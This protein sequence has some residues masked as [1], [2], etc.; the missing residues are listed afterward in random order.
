MIIDHLGEIAPGFFLLGHAAAPVHLYLA[1]RPVLFD[2][3]FSCLDFL[4]A[5]GIEQTLAGRRPE[6]LCL[7]HSH[8]DHVGAAGML[9]RRFPGLTA[10]AS[11]KAAEVLAKPGAR[12]VIA[13]LNQAAARMISRQ[14]D[15]PG[16]GEFEPFT[17]GRTLSD[18]ERI[19]LGEGR[20]LV[21]YAAPGHTWDMMAYYLPR[22]KVLVASESVGCSDMSGHIITEFL[23]DY[24]AYMD[25]MERLS[26]LDV[27]V[28]CQGH[29][30]A[31]TGEDA[32]AFFPRSMA[33]GRK[34][35]DWVMQLLDKHH[36]QVEAVVAAVK[37]AEYDPMPQ[38]KQPEPAYL[39][40]LGAR[41][42]HLAEVRAGGGAAG[43]PT[44][45]S[46]A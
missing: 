21:A 33:E 7:T 27:K 19:D 16:G 9:L 46:P 3:G 24:Q 12:R 37:A 29:L 44:R 10:C 40:N 2:A 45:N 1:P 25:S 39:L 22:E 38:P 17:V 30:F 32:R 23:V 5:K 42:R 8:F 6:L 20:E 13:E 14:W 18:G 35:R 31:Y 4:Y 28:L 43:G 41:V 34:F 26:R 11:P 15:R 36:G